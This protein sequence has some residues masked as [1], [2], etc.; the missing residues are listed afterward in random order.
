MI[1]DYARGSPISLRSVKSASR[2]PIWP[3]EIGI[4]SS[5]VRPNQV[6]RLAM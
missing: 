3:I 1:C 4:A 5:C 2:L 6:N